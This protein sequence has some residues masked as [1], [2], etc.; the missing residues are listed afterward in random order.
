M[1]SLLHLLIEAHLD[2]L[3]SARSELEGGSN[4]ICV[5]THLSLGQR[6]FLVIVSVEV[7]QKF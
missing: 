6:H 2:H 7:F 1:A 4:V 3:D 5:I